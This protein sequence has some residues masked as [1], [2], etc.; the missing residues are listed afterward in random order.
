MSNRNLF[1][2]PISGEF[3]FDYD[4]GMFTNIPK[5]IEW[6]PDDGISEKKYG[7]KNLTLNLTMNCNLNCRYCWQSHD[8]RHDMSLPII[9]RW[10]DFFLNQELN[11][12]AKILYFGGE[13]LIRLD[14]IRYC[15]DKVNQICE[16]R[17]IPKP[18]QQMFTNATLINDDAISLI[19]QEGIFLITSIDGNDEINSI[20]RVDKSGHPVQH[21]I[22]ESIH[23]LQK[24]QIPFGV[25]STMSD[26]NFDVD[27][28]IRYIL[29][30]IK[31]TSI[32]F[33]LRFDR[34]FMQKYQNRS[35]ISFSSFFKAWDIIRN[36]NVENLN[37]KKRIIPLAM[38]K[39]LRNSSSASKNKL[40]VMPNGT[41][42]PFNSV[43]QFPELQI[44]PV[45]NWIDSFRS[46]WKRDILANDKCKDCSAAFICGQGSAFSSYLEYGDFLHPPFLHCEYCFALLSYVKKTITDSLGA[47][48]P[49]GYVVSKDDFSRIFHI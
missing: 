44:V 21:L 4:Y 17:G 31:P 10:L 29:E 47:I 35:D 22:R 34:D 25:C 12:P 48:V 1:F 46:Q 9:D 19:K 15:T 6:M 18:K 41:V 28:T 36:A 33:G 13:P 23:R 2:N 49:N 43:V 45:D 27:K 26:L 16:I 37:F 30:E 5:H 42:S 8:S 38:K 39:P 11:S 3:R 32:E 24:E 7:F 14:L 40:A 20:N